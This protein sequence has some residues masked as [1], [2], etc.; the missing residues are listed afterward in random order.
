MD[1]K[2]EKLDQSLS[3]Y[4]KGEQEI[5]NEL[6]PYRKTLAKLEAIREVPDRDPSVQA[7]ARQAFLEQASSMP[8]PV[9][10][11]SNRRL[12]GWNIIFRKERSPMTTI[13]GFVLALVVAFGGAG[14][15][16]YAAQDS[17]PNEPLYPVKQ[18]TEQVRLA[19]TTDTEAEVHLLLD[20]SEE[21]VGEM[22]ALANQGLEVP[23]ETQLRLQEHLQLALAEA[24][25]LGD[26]A[27]EGILNQ[28][29]TMAQNQ[30]Q[31]MQQAKQ[32]TPEG[33]SSEAIQNAITAMNQVRQVAQDGLEDPLTFRQRQGSNRPENAPDQPENVPPGKSNDAGSQ[34]GEGSTGQGY[35]DGTGEGGGAYGDGYGDGTGEG[36]GANGDGYGDGTG[37]GGGA[38][39]NGYGDGSGDGGGAYGD[40]NG[41]GVCDCACGDAACDCTVECTPQGPQNGQKGSGGMN[42]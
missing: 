42:H 15:T 25:Q 34:S 19:L 29:Q 9:S 36:G 26:A 18:F 39:G 33:A 4:L 23:E 30:I 11:T 14:T 20:L 41:D 31:A 37:E 6:H 24:A 16:A 40:S 13:L 10:K 22:V 28:V 17:L 1:E 2:S 27:L 8:K 3:E 7:V 21:R 35:G 12:K 5:P 32:N 38:Y